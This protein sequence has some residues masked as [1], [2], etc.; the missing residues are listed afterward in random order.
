MSSGSTLDTGESA[1]TK[2][3][4]R[5][6][7]FLALQLPIAAKAQ[8]QASETVFRHYTQQAQTVGCGLEYSAM[9]VDEFARQ[10][11][12]VGVTGSL[13]WASHPKAGIALMFKLLAVDFL[14]GPQN[15]P[16][17]FKVNYAYAKIGEKVFKVDQQISCE[18]PEG[19]CGVLWTNKAM[20]AAG[21][22]GGFKLYFGRRERSFDQE[23]IAA[24]VK[25]PDAEKF[26][27]CVIELGEQAL[28]N[29]RTP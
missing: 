25:L 9:L 8:T 4:I 13:M 27:A 2:T 1:M 3:R 21:A 10:G 14:Q 22:F 19:F 16:T 18:K 23:V 17:L 20:D 24:P 26:N 7:I 15:P 28:K 29:F 5:A 6:A 11:Q 12:L